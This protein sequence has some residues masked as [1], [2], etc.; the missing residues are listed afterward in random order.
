MDD[1]LTSQFKNPKLTHLPP[2]P[3]NH[4]LLQKANQVQRNA[5]SIQQLVRDAYAQH[6]F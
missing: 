2:P 5:I 1:N 6:G 3:P 4:P